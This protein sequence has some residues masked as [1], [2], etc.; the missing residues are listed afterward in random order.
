MY[1]QRLRLQ[2]NWKFVGTVFALRFAEQLMNV[3]LASSRWI[4]SEG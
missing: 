3:G 1:A 4:G 2:N